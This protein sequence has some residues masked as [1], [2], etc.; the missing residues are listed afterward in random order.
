[1]SDLAG[2]FAVSESRAGLLMIALAAPQPFLVPIMGVIADRTG[3][4]RIFVSGLALFG[5]AGG[6]I[7]LTTSFDLALVCR[8]LQGVGFSAAMP[9][10]IVYFGDLYEGSRETTAQGFRM[11]GINSIY[12]V[13]PFLAGVMFVHS[14]RFPFLL[15][16]IAIPLAVGALLLLPDRLQR[17]QGR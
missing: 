17:Q 3:R 15:Y 14:W 2:V 1:V 13:S 8:F 7:S 9:M 11:V 6:A 16:L 10:T 4:K 12:I 5:T